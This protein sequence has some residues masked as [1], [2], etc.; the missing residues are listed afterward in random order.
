[1]IVLTT[2]REHDTIKV[3]QASAR[4][5]TNANLHVVIVKATFTVIDSTAAEHSASRVVSAKLRGLTTT[6]GGLGNRGLIASLTTLGD[7]RPSVVTNNGANEIRLDDLDV[8]QRVGADRGRL[9]VGRANLTNSKNLT[10]KLSLS[11]RANQRETTRNGDSATGLRLGVKRLPTSSSNS[12]V[13]NT[14]ILAVRT[15]DSLALE[16]GRNLRQV[17]L[18]TQLSLDVLVAG[19]EQGHEDQQVLGTSRKTARVSRQLLNRVPIVIDDCLEAELKTR[20]MLANL[21]E[22]TVA[23]VRESR[24]GGQLRNRGQRV[25]DGREAAVVNRHRRNVRV[26]R[27]VSSRSEVVEKNLLSNLRPNRIVL[28]VRADKLHV[29]SVNKH[30]RCEAISGDSLLQTRLSDLV[31]LEGTFEQLVELKL[32]LFIDQ[33]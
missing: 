27:Q 19:V 13:G 4:N 29:S 24:V 20:T 1:M 7:K 8:G 28:V 9:A 16:L 33:H 23:G 22:T 25:L 11:R 32:V 21:N 15:S 2:D 31:A 18:T 6:H 10:R 12:T 3:Q 30:G 14:R 26:Q 17:K 5:L